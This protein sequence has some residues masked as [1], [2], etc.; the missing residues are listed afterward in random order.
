MWSRVWATSSQHWH[1]SN[2]RPAYT[3]KEKKDPK[4]MKP[5][6]PGPKSEKD[7]GDNYGDSALTASERN[8]N[9]R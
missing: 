9:L 8:P 7:S 4:K 3:A 5:I 6:F 2:Q 1:S